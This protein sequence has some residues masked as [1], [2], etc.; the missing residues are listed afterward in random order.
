MDALPLSVDGL[1]PCAHRSVARSGFM[2]HCGDCTA[3]ELGRKRLDHAGRRRRRHHAAE[4]EPCRS[5][6]LGE[7][8]RRALLAADGHHQHLDIEHLGRRRTWL[9]RHDLLADKQAAMRRQLRADQPQD[10][11]AMLIAPIVDDVL[12][13]IGVAP[14]GTRSKKLPASTRKRPPQESRRS[15]GTPATTSG[16]SNSTPCIA[17]YF[18]R[19]EASRSPCPPPRSARRSMPEKSYDARIDC[20]A[21]AE[22]PDIARWKVSACSGRSANRSKIG[23]P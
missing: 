3:V 19:T 7:L 10:I 13:H 17:G 20:A 5:K 1:E 9:L 4:L 12:H 18:C 22:P 11:A 8:A 2:L 14:C 6:Q 23:L 15:P 21:M 16:R